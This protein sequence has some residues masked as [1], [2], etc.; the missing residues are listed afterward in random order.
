MLL[1]LREF[2]SVD[3]KLS[4]NYY[5]HPVTSYARATPL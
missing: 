2:C 5:T 4:I 3:T 1:K